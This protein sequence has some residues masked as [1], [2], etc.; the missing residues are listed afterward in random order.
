MG[1]QGL[2]AVMGSYLLKRGVLQIPTHD[3]DYYLQCPMR[4]YLNGWKNPDAQD[5]PVISDI[6][7]YIS[8]LL[9]QSVRFYL[10]RYAFDG[11][12]PSFNRVAKF[13][14]ALW[15]YVFNYYG[16][17]PSIE[18]KYINST[19]RLRQFYKKHSKNAVENSKLV[20]LVYDYKYALNYNNVD[21][22]GG[23]DFVF[24]HEIAGRET[25]Q[26][27]YLDYTYIPGTRE[28]MNTNYNILCSVFKLREQ[29]GLP[30]DSIKYYSVR[31][32]SWYTI[33]IHYTNEQIYG[34][35]EDICK[36]LSARI[37]FRNPG[38][39]CRECDFNDRA[40]CIY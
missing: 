16:R 7:T 25:I 1:A 15:D 22:V 4:F 14:N 9:A 36:A 23:L 34:I 39:Y 40:M 20:P 26:L 29:Y 8:G 24:L 18:T 11:R 5:E 31:H 30:C 38:K 35:I 21:L 27:G 10:M 12:P 17:S 37:H 2:Q 13:W 28:Y 6:D 3:I 32:V 19:F 33:K